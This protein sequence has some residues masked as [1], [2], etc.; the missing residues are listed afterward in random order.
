MHPIYS[1]QWP[2]RLFVLFVLLL[3]LFLLL[4]F[5]LVSLVRLVFLLLLLLLFFLL[6]FDLACLV[7]LVLLLFCPAATTG[8]RSGVPLRELRLQHHLRRRFRRCG[9]PCGGSSS[10]RD[11]RLALCL[12][13]PAIPCRAPSQ[14]HL[15]LAH[16]QRRPRRHGARPLGPLQH[17]RCLRDQ[18]AFPRWRGL[19]LHRLGGQLLLR[20][21][22]ELLDHG[23]RQVARV[24]SGRL[25]GR[26]CGPE[27]RRGRPPLGVRPRLP[28]QCQ[29]RALLQE[30]LPLLIR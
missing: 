25:R 24:P 16:S 5:D 3:L 4:L 7:R 20:V 30:R 14:L 26:C 11:G 1:P 29:P 8:R 9:C 19:C 10:R 12:R 6:L 15:Q 27:G 18:P 13:R 28:A 21:R 2:A 17:R 23:W 22:H